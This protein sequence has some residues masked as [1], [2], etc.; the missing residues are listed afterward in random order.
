M[1]DREFEKAPVLTLKK[2]NWQYW[3]EEIELALQSKGMFYTYLETELEYCRQAIFML[4]NNLSWGLKNLSIDDISIM[5]ISLS[6]QEDELTDKKSKASSIPE[7][8]TL[9]T[10]NY[11]KQ[12]KYEKNA[13]TVLRLI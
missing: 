13:A 7:K 6:K 11:Q 3:L 4:L 1:N 9:Y 12:E 10:I 5:H 8:N 2:K